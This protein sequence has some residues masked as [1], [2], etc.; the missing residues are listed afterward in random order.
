MSQV[1]FGM[2]RRAALTAFGASLIVPTMTLPASAAEMSNDA[3]ALEKAVEAMR[4]A[5]VAGDGKVL[6][7]VLHD[8]LTYSH[9]DGHQQ[10]KE[11][12][13]DELAG[14]HSFASLALSAQTVDIV[15]NVGVVRHVFDSVNNLPDGKTSSAHIRVLQCWIKAGKGW[16]L[17]A[18]AS[19][20]IPKA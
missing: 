12:V 13:L 1:N 2:S 9:S 20:P 8:R 18:R 17:L 15:G 6:K 11:Q 4:A 10:T 3:V 19:T 16:K 5:M 14:K 7:A